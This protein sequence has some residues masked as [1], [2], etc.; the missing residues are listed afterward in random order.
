MMYVV[1]YIYI[2]DMNFNNNNRIKSVYTLYHS[3]HVHTCSAAV[4]GK[5]EVWLQAKPEI[6]GR[7]S[8]SQLQSLVARIQCGEW[9]SIL[10][11]LLIDR[12]KDGVSSEEE[13]LSR[14]IYRETLFLKLAVS[15]HVNLGEQVCC[16]NLCMLAL[17]AI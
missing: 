7:D 5:R 1:I 8:E 17:A 9:T 15:R 3:R 13:C 14:S 12:H 11:S 6:K 4:L 10:S 16:D 2:Y